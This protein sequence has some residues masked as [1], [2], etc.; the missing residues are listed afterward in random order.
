MMLVVTLPSRGRYG[1]MLVASFTFFSLL[2]WY[3]ARCFLFAVA[4]VLRLRWCTSKQPKLGI[5]PELSFSLELVSP[6]QVTHLP[7][8]WDLLVPLAYTPDRRDHWRL[9]SLP[10]DTA[11]CGANE[12]AFENALGGTMLGASFNLLLAVAMV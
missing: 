7:P 5:T 9:V 2:L 10:K 8:V 1:M 4:V 11:K 12:I 3:D 6:L